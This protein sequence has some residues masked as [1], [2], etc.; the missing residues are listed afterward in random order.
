MTTEKTLAQLGY[1]MP[2]EW[3]PQ[4][5]IIL[6]WPHNHDTWPGKFAPVPAVYVNIIREIVDHQDL[7][8][9]VCSHQ[10]ELEAR[11][12]LS[13]GC[14]PQERIRFYIMPTRDTWCRDFGPIYVTREHKGKSAAAY[15]H[16]R[17]VT[18]WIFNGWGGKY[19]EAGYPDDDLVPTRLAQLNKTGYVT[20]PVILEGGSIDVNGQGTVITS[21]SCLLNDNRNATL[22]RPDIEKIIGDHLGITNF[23]WVPQGIAGDDTD[24]HID[25]TVR[26]VNEN[27]LICMTEP[28]PSDENHLTL[29]A[30][31]DSLRDAKDQNGRPIS[32][33]KIPMPD[34]VD[35]E[36]E[37][38]PASYANFLITNHKVLMPTYRCPKKD[39]HAL[40]ILQELF[41]TR[42]VTGIDCTDLV[43]GLGAIHCISQ[44]V[45]SL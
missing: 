12:L 16:E 43:L 18:D 1:R 8:L 31:A 36:D 11:R 5:A 33:V 15:R 29:K 27:T 4:E 21:E 32:V 39:A 20:V 2:A 41:S 42:R 13:L 40:A 19:Y 24:G 22:T 28:D 44:Q 7:W 26:F 14:V 38:L 10:M 17:I 37:R 34:R 6:S 45:P 35:F 30:V 25:D 23:I 9:L 3:S